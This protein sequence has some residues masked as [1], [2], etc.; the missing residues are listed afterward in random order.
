VSPAR[1]DTIEALAALLETA[2]TLAQTLLGDK[3]LQ[4]A[5]RALSSL[6]PE[7]REV[8]STA[9]EHGVAW[10]RVN[11]SI[12]AMNGVHPRANGVLVASAG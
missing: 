12:S 9:L 4:R 10:R 6:P 11:E 3:A 7:D 8:I 5:L 1:P 2:Q